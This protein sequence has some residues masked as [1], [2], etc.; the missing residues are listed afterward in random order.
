MEHNLMRLS[1]ETQS[2]MTPAITPSFFLELH[3]TLEQEAAVSCG[4]NPLSCQNDD[5]KACLLR[6][7]PHP[8]RVP[9][10]GCR[11]PRDSS[12][13]SNFSEQGSRANVLFLLWAS[14]ADLP[15]R[16]C[17]VLDHRL[18]S[19]PGFLST[20]P[21][22]HRKHEQCSSKEPKATSKEKPRGEK[23]LG[24]LRL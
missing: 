22:N 24:R 1:K 12:C 11:E 23:I 3:Q 13:F 17:F 20:A 8:A 4:S 10:T 9:G 18:S 19:I 15:G 5:L 21:T 6:T 2:L 7:S 16:C 14:P